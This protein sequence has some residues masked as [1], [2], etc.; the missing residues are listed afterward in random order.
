MNLDRQVTETSEVMYGLLEKGFGED[1]QA[2]GLAQKVEA[3]FGLGVGTIQDESEDGVLEVQ[4]LCGREGKLGIVVSGESEDFSFGCI[5]EDAFAGTI[6]KEG[7]EDKGEV[8]VWEEGVRI[9]KVN[10]ES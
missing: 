2:N 5:D 6:G 9:I 1:N 4:E 3:S 8:R 7:L 10:L